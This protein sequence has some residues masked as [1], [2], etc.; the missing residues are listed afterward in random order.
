MRILSGTGLR[1]GIGLLGALLLALGWVGGVGASPDD[2]PSSS[3][4][5]ITGV[6]VL[7]SWQGDDLFVQL[8]TNDDGQGE[9]WVKISD[10]T[11]IVDPDGNPLPISAIQVGVRITVTHYEFEHGY[12][13]A[14][15]VVV[16]TTSS[17]SGSASAPCPDP[18]QGVVTQATWL[19]DDFFVQLDTNSDGTPE[20]RA[21]IKRSALIE[22]PQGNVLTMN[23]IRPGVTLTL[24]NYKLDDDGYYEAWRVIVG[25]VDPTTISCGSSGTSTSA[26][27]QPIQGT[28]VR[29]FWFG[30]DFF[31]GLDTNSDGQEDIRVKI[32][33]N[34]RITDPQ[35]NPLGFE[36]IR[37]GVTLTLIGYKLDDD[38]YY[39]AWHVIVGEAQTS[40]Q[41]PTDQPIRGT[42]L[43]VVPFGDDLFVRLDADGDGLEDY[44]VKIDSK[45]VIV[46]PN[47]NPV[48]RSTIQVGVTLTVTEYT[49][50]DGYYEAKRVVVEG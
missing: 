22:D 38:G 2:S 28:V 48:D 27:G 20:V 17:T 3:G 16:G 35:G 43:E 30:D 14:K 7:L 25:E 41:P 49:F 23:D 36:A 32:K 6:V 29:T 24:V 40:S 15:R 4:N 34:A 12:Y 37:P 42:V 33:H 46:D 11:L 9:L 45:A 13:E 39:E 21:K 31:V 50:K 44:P 8:D 5:P 1:I 26:T 10:S 18:I 47:G 19:G